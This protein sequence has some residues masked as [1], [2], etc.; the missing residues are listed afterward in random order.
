[1]RH[2]YETYAS[3]TNHTQLRFTVCGSYY[4]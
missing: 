3:L 2:N 1:M 4:E